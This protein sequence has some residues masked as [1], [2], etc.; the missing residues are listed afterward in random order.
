MSPTQEQLE[1][2]RY[3]RKFLITDYSYSDVNQILK[4][5]PACFSE[6]F[7]ERSVNNIYFDTLGMNNYYDN[8][9]GEQKRSKVRIRWYGELFGTIQN[10]VLEYK[11]KNGLLGK[12]KSYPLHAFILDTSFNKSQIINAIDASAL[13]KK[14]SDQLNTLQ[15][16]LLN[17]YKR[18]Y[19]LSADKNFRITIDHHLIYYMIRYHNNT[20]INKSVDNNAIVVELKYDS[21]LETEAKTV[22]NAFPF[23]LTKNSK[24]LQGL[25]RVFQ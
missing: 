13:P 10:P 16:M 22:A 7:H 8:V 5:H 19:F 3:E 21:A 4:Y 17:S 18:K 6:I 14:I 11:L 23:A 9:N 15:P 12:K 20:F 2:L 24:Y 1:P 25:E